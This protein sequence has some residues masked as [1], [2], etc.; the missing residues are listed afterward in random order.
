MATVSHGMVIDSVDSGEADIVRIKVDVVERAKQ[1]Y[2]WDLITDYYCE[3]LSLIG[4]KSQDRS[5]IIQG[6]PPYPTRSCSVD[7]DE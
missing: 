5:A 2:T 6:A 1:F 4:S 7:R 3:L